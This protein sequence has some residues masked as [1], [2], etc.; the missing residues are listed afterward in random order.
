MSTRDRE[1]EAPGPLKFAPKWARMAAPEP[2]PARAVSARERAAASECPSA[3]TQARI[4]AQT[5]RSRDLHRSATCLGAQPPERSRHRRRDRGNRPRHGNWQSSPAP[6]KVTWRSRSCAS[7]WRWR[8]IS[9]RNLR[10]ATTGRRCSAWSAGL[11]GS[12]P[13]RRSRRIGFVWISAPRN[14]PDDQGFALAAAQNALLGRRPAAPAVSRAG[15][16]PASLNSGSF[17]PAVFQPPAAAGR[18]GRPVAVA[19]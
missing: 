13:W 2:A 4:G 6:S 9:R 7:A 17:K 5:P 10:C 12:S 18:R 15:L 14:Q 19:G 3:G 8:P 11:P 16:G 1:P